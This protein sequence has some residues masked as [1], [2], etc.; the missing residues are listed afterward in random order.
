M[1]EALYLP[2]IILVTRKTPLTLLLE[3]HGTLAQAHFYLASRGQDIAGYEQA[4]EQFQAAL[5]QVLASIPPDRR[6][7]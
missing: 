5:A 2:R 4:H 6:R 1:S 7:A 3:Q